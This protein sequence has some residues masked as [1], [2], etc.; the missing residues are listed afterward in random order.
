MLCYLFTRVSGDRKQRAANKYIMSTMYLGFAVFVFFRRYSFVSY[1]TL[2][3]TALLFAWLGDFFLVF[4]FGRGGDY[5]LS[6]NICFAVYEQIILVDN[7]HSW[8]EYVWAFAAAAALIG[9]FIYACGR[10]P[11]IFKLGKMR[12]PMTF[13]LSS[14]F[15]HGMIGLAM[16]SLMPGTGYMMMGIGSILFMISDMI[17]VT[18]N[19]ILGKNKWLIRANSITY[20]TGLL[21]IVLSMAFR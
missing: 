6:A 4:D 17:L 10:W 21:L 7:G 15:T 12:W 14:I 19:F 8:K 2:L 16:A 3:M 9:A 13:Y 1:H 18:Y 5:F 11:H 20:F